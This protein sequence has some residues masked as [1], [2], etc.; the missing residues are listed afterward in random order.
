MEEN[1]NLYFKNWF[2]SILEKRNGKTERITWTI[3]I[4]TADDNPQ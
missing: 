2:Y 4:Q 1:R 3:N